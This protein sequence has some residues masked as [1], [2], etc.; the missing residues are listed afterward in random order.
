MNFKWQLLLG[1]T[2]EIEIPMGIEFFR[3]S[4][5]VEKRSF[6]LQLVMKCC[7]RCD[8]LTWALGKLK[9]KTA[10]KFNFLSHV[11]NFRSAGFKAS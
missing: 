1:K 2:L 4:N 8:A 10:I 3:L 11:S 7:G 6:F 5:E 9:F